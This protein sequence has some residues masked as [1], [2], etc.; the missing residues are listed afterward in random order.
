M[1]KIGILGED[2]YDTSSIQL[3]L[4]KKYSSKVQFCRLLKGTKGSQLDNAKVIGALKIEIEKHKCE[5]VIIMRDL[6]GL[7]SQTDLLNQRQKWFDRLNTAGQHIFLLNIW[8][9][10]AMIFA[11]IDVFNKKFKTTV[12]GDRNPMF[13]NDPK[14]EL[15]SATYK[16]KR[17]FGV[18]DCP[19]IFAELNL[20]KLI[21]KCKFL[22]NF[23]Q[24]F[25]TRLA[26]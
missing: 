8:E 22:N 19:E 15:I 13:I 9:L 25:D 20:D 1:K 16:T 2:P 11:D 14:G 18:S 23:V 7:I 5:A 10:E 21:T 17:K 3:L 26:K 12:K 6:D 24:E 4:E